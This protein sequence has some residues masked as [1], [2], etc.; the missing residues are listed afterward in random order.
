[1][2]DDRTCSCRPSNKVNANEEHIIVEAVSDYDRLG[3]PISRS[4][5][6]DLAASLISAMPP[7]QQSSL[8][9]KK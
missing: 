4:G 7:A 2:G 5:L 9:F 3:A 1:M 6:Q 8:G